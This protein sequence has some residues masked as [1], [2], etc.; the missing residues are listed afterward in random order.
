V[1]HHYHIVSGE[2]NIALAPINDVCASP[3]E[4]PPEGRPS[5]FGVAVAAAT[6]ANDFHDD[7]ASI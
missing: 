1:Q 3:V 7:W 5:V 2:L 6:V 4:R